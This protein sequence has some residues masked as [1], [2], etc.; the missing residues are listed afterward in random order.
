M[1]PPMLIIMYGLLSSPALLQWTVKVLLRS[2]NT[3]NAIIQSPSMGDPMISH[4]VDLGYADF[5]QLVG[6]DS[7]YPK[8]PSSVDPTLLSF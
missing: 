8:D 2:R 1:I 5:K 3:E 4:T 7:L 6:K